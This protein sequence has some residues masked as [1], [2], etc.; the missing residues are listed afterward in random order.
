MKMVAELTH[1]LC[2]HFVESEKTFKLEECLNIFKTFCEKVEQ[3]E[4]VIIMIYFYSA[5]PC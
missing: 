2:I 5:F 3:C 4:K 1:K